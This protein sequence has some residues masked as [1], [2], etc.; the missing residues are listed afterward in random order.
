MTFGGCNTLT[1]NALRGGPARGHWSKPDSI[2][3]LTSRNINTRVRKS[4]II[5]GFSSDHAAPTLVIDIKKEN[6][7]KGF[8]KLNSTL[9]KEE[10]FKTEIVNCISTTILDNH[11]ANPILLWD[12]IN[13]ESGVQLLN[14]PLDVNGNLLITLNYWKKP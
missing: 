7:G 8:W 12:T 10:K 14:T 13:V 1:Y 11:S 9:L 6:G 3:F 2:F 5:P 4:D